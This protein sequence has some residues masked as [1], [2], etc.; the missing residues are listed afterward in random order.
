MA[1]K[2]CYLDYLMVRNETEESLRKQVEQKYAAFKGLTEVL[3][4]LEKASELDNEGERSR[5]QEELYQTLYKALQDAQRACQ[6]GKDDQV[7]QTEAK[8]FGIYQDLTIPG[9]FLRLGN[10]RE[11]IEQL[12]NER[13]PG[14]AAGPQSWDFVHVPGRM[15]ALTRGFYADLTRTQ[16]NLLVRRAWLQDALDA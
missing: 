3:A 7:L 12:K 6:G 13:G 11:R 2:P 9:A 15:R 1:Q 5:H 4:R 10:A 8:D 16:K 14:A